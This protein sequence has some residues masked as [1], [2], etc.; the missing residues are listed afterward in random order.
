MIGLLPALL[1]GV[2]DMLRAVSVAL[3]TVSR[4]YADFLDEGSAEAVA[5]AR[6]AMRRLVWAAEQSL[7]ARGDSGGAEPHPP[8]AGTPPG[9]VLIWAL[10]EEV[11]RD[12][13]RRDL[14]VRSLLS[15]Y[16]VG[17][18]AA[19]RYI[20][21]TAVELGL[22]ADAL[23]ALAEEVFFLVDELGSVTTTG[24]LDAQ[25]EATSVREQL[26]DALA[27]RLLSDHADP[28]AVQAAARRAGWSLPA[29]AAVVFLRSGAEAGRAALA[30]L[31]PQC[32]PLRHTPLPGAILPGPTAPGGRQRLAAALAGTSALVGPTVPLDGLA[33]SARLV[34]VAART[35]P[36]PDGAGA[37]VFVEDRL[38]LLL[39]HQDRQLLAALQERCLRPLS[40]VPAATR[41]SL[42]LTL[43][44][45]LRHMGNRASMARE[46]G[47]H[48]QTVRYR[49]GRLRELFGAAL[50]DPDVRL[51]LA[52]AVGFDQ[53]AAPGP[54]SRTAFRGAGPAPAPAR[55][56]APRAGAG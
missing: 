42:R 24:Y 7:R 43:R 14:P 19:W 46:L 32:L 15:A 37:P 22:P 20:A 39:V 34:E 48:P 27:E 53:P 11:G 33:H 9:D 45:W 35:L 29:T 28:A 4:E 5:P 51:R 2:P 47:V 36:P 54:A 13:R 3:R 30:R 41:E 17:G 52:L 23:A 8:G 12:Q 26:Y 44:A 18:R 1:R 16:Q 55:P 49:V 31:G 21:A 50:E 10:F 6:V 25:A 56:A 38:D 40:G